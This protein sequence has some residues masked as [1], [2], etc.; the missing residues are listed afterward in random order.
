MY[1]YT[2]KLNNR[3]MKKIN[4]LL[5]VIFFLSTGSFYHQVNAQEKKWVEK[6][7]KI[8]EKEKEFEVQKAIEEQKKAMANQKRAQERVVID[9]KDHQE[10]L[11]DIM[12][13][14]RVEMESID[15]DMGGVRI[16]GKSGN[17]TYT[18]DEPFIHSPDV[19][20]FYNYSYGDN[21]EG[22]TWE[23][24]KAVKGSSFERDFT[25]DVEPTVSSV[26]MSI[27][28]DCKEGEIRFKITMPD[29]R[30]YSDIVIDEFGSLNWRKS[31]SISET[32]NQ[33]KTGEWDF[34]ICS[35]EASGYFKISLKAY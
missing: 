17:R 33:D 24:S 25:F 1:L 9:F 22:T 16:F 11:D 10:E 35:T 14:V 7:E 19:R 34:E 29:G 27:T 2:V 13:D 30:M 28:G 3:K 18:F 4:V 15:S 5:I 23:F 20:T 21:S 8:S 31:F 32:E 26:I 12:M 6:K